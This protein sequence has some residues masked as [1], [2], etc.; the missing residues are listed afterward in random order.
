MKA[1]QYS[2]ESVLEH[3]INIEEN[4]KQQFARVQ[5][6]YIVE[7]T[8]LNDLEEKLERALVS[9]TKE[10]P[11]NT[12][13]RKNLQQYIHFLREKV[14]LQRQLTL[15]TN[16]KLENKRQELIFAQKDRKTIERH[17][18]KAFDQYQKEIEKQEQNTI[19]ELALYAYMRK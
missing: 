16:K 12:I 1:F 11:K 4:Q 2:M 9:S 13:E 8:K 6:E 7:K 18:E 5:N 10:T 3:R 17:K 14:E 19:D 15:E